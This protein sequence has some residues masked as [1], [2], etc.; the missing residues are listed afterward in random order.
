M[1]ICYDG[2]PGEQMSYQ[3]KLDMTNRKQ[4][5]ISAHKALVH[6]GQ[7]SAANSVLRLLV[8]KSVCLGLNDDEYEAECALNRAGLQGIPG[9]N[10]NSIRFRI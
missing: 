2:K 3:N 8:N 9:R 6:S 4:K 1:I 10:F 5:A 7:L